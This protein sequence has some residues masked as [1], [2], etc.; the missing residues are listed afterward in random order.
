M[1]IVKNLIKNTRYGTKDIMG[2]YEVLYQ[3]MPFIK[4]E[5]WLKVSPEYDICIEG[6]PRSANSFFVSAFD[7]N[8]PDMKC[9]HHMH[10]PMQVVKAVEYGVPCVVLIR[11]PTD[12]IASVLVVDRSLSMK[13]AIQSYIHFYE[14]TW[15]VRNA[16]TVADFKEATQRPDQIIEK[17][18]QRHGTSFQMEHLNP[19]I[20]KKIFKG[21]REAQENLGLPETLVAIPTKT[22]SQ[23]KQELLPKLLAHPLLPRANKLYEKFSNLSV[24]KS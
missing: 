20:E 17:V 19:S 13:L 23:I 24:Y 14:R 7:L 9:A 5:P 2:R 16:V 1:T 3:L 12:A 10:V 15:P 18:N 22:K 21:L 4:K 6:F 8:N 11:N